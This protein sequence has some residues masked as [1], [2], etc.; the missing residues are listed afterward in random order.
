MRSRVAEATTDSKISQ[1]CSM[2]TTLG[3]TLESF[4]LHSIL[5]CS[6][7]A[8][9]ISPTSLSPPPFLQPVVYA[10]PWPT[11]PQNMKTYTTTI[12][13]KT[14]AAGTTYG[15]TSPRP[16]PLSLRNPLQPSRHFGPE[17]RIGA[18]RAHPQDPTLDYLDVIE[19]VE[20]R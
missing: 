1:R 11:V 6:G 19:S 9:A 20:C 12:A 16:I 18:S 7:F 13:T 14:L 3:T 8:V 10:Q 17:R 15:T 4:Q 5:A 2:L